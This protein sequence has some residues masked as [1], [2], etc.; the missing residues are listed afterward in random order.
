[1]GMAAIAAVALIDELKTWTQASTAQERIAYAPVLGSMID[2]LQVERGLSVGFVGSAGK[3]FGDAMARQRPRVDE[4]LGGART[5]LTALREITRDPALSGAIGSALDALGNIRARVSALDISPGEVAAWYTGLISD[6]ISMSAEAT[7][8]VVDVDS[9]R[10]ATVYDS[11]LDAKERAGL[12][13]AAGAFGFGR[14]AFTAPSYARFTGLGAEQDAFVN[15]M[16]EHSTPRERETIAQTL[17]GPAVDRVKALRQMAQDSVFGGVLTATGPEWFEASTKRISLFHDLEVMAAD[18]LLESVTAN[19]NAAR[20]R[21]VMIVAVAVAVTAICLVSIVLSVRSIRRPIAGIV[22]K[23]GRVSDGETD[24]VVTE[25]ARSDEIG[26]IGRALDIFRIRE[27]DRARLVQAEAERQAHEQFRSR[28]IEDALDAF[29]SRSEAA[30]VDMQSVSS[31][32]ADVSTSLSAAADRTARGSTDAKSSTATASE[33][34]QGVAIAV[35]QLHSSIAEVSG[36]VSASQKATEEAAEAAA[37]ASTRVDGLAKAA[38]SIDNVANMIAAIAEQT[39]LLALNATIEAE[40]A[41]AAGRGF[42]V[43]AHEV[44]LLA[45]QTADATTEIARQIEGIQAETRAAV[46]GI[47][48]IMARFTE[49]RSSALA[50]SSVMTQQ[51]AAARDIGD[52]MRTASSGAQGATDRVVVVVAAAAETSAGAH[53]VAGA[54]ERISGVSSTLRSVVS[55]FLGEVRAA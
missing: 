1:M 29:R 30:L 20:D 4:M 50:I 26:D 28:R 54:A 21:F 14:G 22:D 11:V 17:S 43:V 55:D 35:D 42:A 33:A 2:V 23:L 6:L 45:N 5:A 15:F 24:M 39:N 27:A 51:A 31:A 37:N 12:E 52:G 7:H 10:L 16:I 53:N 41:G 36:R 47:G 49:L 9:A 40:R 44:K 18:A 34:V 25:A 3:A 38:E 48:D 19:A 32:L 46:A 8:T 13:R